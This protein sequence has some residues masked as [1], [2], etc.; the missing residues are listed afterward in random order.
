MKR[1]ML[2]VGFILSCSPTVKVVEKT[3]VEEK[4]EDPY[5][6]RIRQDFVEFLRRAKERG[7]VGR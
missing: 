1:L 4:R 3:V 5:K 7:Q 2:V 6:E